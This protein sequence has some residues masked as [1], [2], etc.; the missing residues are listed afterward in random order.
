MVISTRLFSVDETMNGLQ[1]RDVDDL[2]T[3]QI[4][5]NHSELQSL[6]S[7]L[8]LAQTGWAITEIEMAA[9][10]SKELADIWKFVYV[11]KRPQVTL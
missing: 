4:K 10:D 9:N 2:S 11:V 1:F 3:A 8:Q 5:Y 7:N 6:K